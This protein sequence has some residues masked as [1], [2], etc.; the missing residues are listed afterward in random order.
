MGFWFP[1]QLPWAHPDKNTEIEISSSFGWQT[2]QAVTSF[3][4]LLIQLFT[5]PLIHSISSH[6]G[7]S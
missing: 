5:H 4:P 1:A 3:V 6:C 2:T 7:Q